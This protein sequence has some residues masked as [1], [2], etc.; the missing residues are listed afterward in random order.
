VGY[1]IEA[2]TFLGF[3]GEGVLAL[4]LG[5]AICLNKSD[6]CLDIF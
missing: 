5:I 6:E 1:V 3:G 4:N 2:A